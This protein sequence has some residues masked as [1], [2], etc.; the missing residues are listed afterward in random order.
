MS[1]IL[2][3]HK[4]DYTLFNLLGRGLFKSMSIKN[5]EFIVILIFV[6]IL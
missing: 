1:Y 6:S 4:I 2:G 3:E 5:N